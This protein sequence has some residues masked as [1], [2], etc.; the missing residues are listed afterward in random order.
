MSGLF[1]TQQGAF[2]HWCAFGEPPRLM[3]GRSPTRKA[4]DAVCPQRRTL[5]VGRW[6][7]GGGATHRTG[8]DRWGRRR[9]QQTEPKSQSA[10]LGVTSEDLP[11]FDQQRLGG[12][13]VFKKVDAGI[14]RAGD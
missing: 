10:L 9:A 11:R 6:C 1:F 4:G 5:S 8:E 3:D 12:E 13:R 14:E 7:G 2:F